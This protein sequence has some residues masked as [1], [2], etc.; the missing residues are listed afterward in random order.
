MSS[1]IFLFGFLELKLRLVK[2][3]LIACISAPNILL[4]NV[5]IFSN[6]LGLVTKDYLSNRVR[7]QAQFANSKDMDQITGRNER[8]ETRHFVVFVR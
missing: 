2:F 3:K 4:W 6:L 1:N 7:I 5:V 8:Q